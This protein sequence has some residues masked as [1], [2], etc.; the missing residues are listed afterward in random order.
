M[1]L[2]RYLSQVIIALFLFSMLAG[3]IVTAKASHASTK[4]VQHV[5]ASSVLQWPFSPA[6]G[7]WSILSGYNDDNPPPVDHNCNDT[8]TC[9]ERYGL[10][11][12]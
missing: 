12:Q 8:K 5:N 4:K 9:Y 6:D 11:F 7:P 2:R 3:T 10:D 1:Q